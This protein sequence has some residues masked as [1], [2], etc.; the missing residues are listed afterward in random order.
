MLRDRWG[1]MLKAIGKGVFQEAESFTR[2][3]VNYKRGEGRR[4]AGGVGRRS[5]VG[6][7]G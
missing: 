2:V 5:A 1:N 4:G 3:K 7:R 6:A